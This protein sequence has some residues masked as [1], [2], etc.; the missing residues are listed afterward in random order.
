MNTLIDGFKFAPLH[1]TNLMVRVIK[2]SAG[3]NQEPVAREFAGYGR[4]N[5]GKH[6]RAASIVIE[7]LSWHTWSNMKC[8]FV[9]EGDD[10]FG[11]G[12]YEKHKLIKTHQVN[13]WMD[14]CTLMPP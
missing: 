4:I 2:Y 13:D 14:Q 1:G 11:S 7:T 6:F 8:F 10:G 9:D 12:F 3:R 5:I